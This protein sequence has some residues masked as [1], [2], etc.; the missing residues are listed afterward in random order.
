M[1]WFTRDKTPKARP[2]EKK[3]KVP[4][5]LWSKCGNCSEII[6]NK[7]LERNLSVC[8]KCQ[9]HFRISAADRIALVADEGSFVEI[10]AHLVPDD[11]LGFMDTK[12]YPERVV[13]AQ[14]KA[15]EDKRDADEKE[16]ADLQQELVPT[17]LVFGAIAM[18]VSLLYVLVPSVMSGRTLGKRTQHLKV[19][20][21]DGSKLRFGDAFKRYGLIIILT[22]LFLALPILGPISALIPVGALFAI[23]RWTRNNNMQ[24][25]HDRFAKTIVVSDAQN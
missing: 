2:T 8:P 14:K 11:P 21:E 15:A 18:V 19:L 7:E 24:G 5:G 22:S 9:Y 1:A 13:E 17:R 10:D 25:V 12:P 4:E 16:L 20:R 3:V 23:L 6:Y